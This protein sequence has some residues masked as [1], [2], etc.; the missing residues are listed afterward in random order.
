MAGPGSDTATEDGLLKN[1]YEP[2]IAEGVLNKF[3]LKE[4]FKPKP[5]LKPQTPR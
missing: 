2:V 4:T 3:S 5:S 1:T